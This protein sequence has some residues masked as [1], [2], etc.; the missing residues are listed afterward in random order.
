M[1]PLISVI[2]PIYKVEKY[3]NK[4]VDSIINQTY[5]NLEIILVDDGSPDNCPDICDDYANKD[6]R[7]KVV[8]KVNGGLSDARNAGMAVATGEY[9]SFIDSDDYISE[10]FINEL[11]SAIKAENSDIAECTIVKVYEDEQIPEI[12][13]SN[14][15][16]SFEPQQ[17]LSKLMFEDGFHQHVWNKLYKSDITLDIPFRKGKLN[18]DEFWTYQVFGRA[19]KATI[20]DKT[21]Y[22]YLQRA[23]SIMGNSFNMRRLDALEA[24]AERQEYIEKNFPEL[25]TQAKINLFGSCIFSCQSVMKFMNGKEKRLAKSKI[26]SYVKKCKITLKEAN[27]LEGNNRF[28]FS[29][30]SLCFMLCCKV[31][32]ITGIG[33]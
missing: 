3:L 22:F 16:N 11:Y 30:A 15:V 4:C 12:N 2:V 9:V 25:T 1:Q 10:G 5:K 27:T 8:H 20:V 17:A 33:F 26:K 7:I 13:D 18:E 29:F 32:S 21:M 31:R 6:S 19:K 23:G 14:C 28:W 24:K